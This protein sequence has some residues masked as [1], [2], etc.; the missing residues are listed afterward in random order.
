MINKEDSSKKFNIAHDF[1]HWR[2]TEEGTLLLRGHFSKKADMS[3]PI[4]FL[5]YQPVASKKTHDFFA[6]RR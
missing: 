2:Q 6:S 1:A 5:T 4:T 3:A